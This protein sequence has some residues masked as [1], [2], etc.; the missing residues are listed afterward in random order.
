MPDLS[1]STAIV[2]GGARGIGLT[3]AS[4][5]AQCGASIGPVS[6]AGGVAMITVCVANTADILRELTLVQDPYLHPHLLNETRNYA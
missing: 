1:G 6:R 5:L 4:A 3:M 2:T